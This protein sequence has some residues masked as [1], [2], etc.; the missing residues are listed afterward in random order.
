MS[1]EHSFETEE[2]FFCHA[3]IRPGVPLNAQRKIDLLE[4]D[5]PFLS[6]DR[7]FGKIVVHGHTITD[8]VVIKPNRI[9][10]D[11]GAAHHGPLS[12]IELPSLKI[13]EGRGK[14]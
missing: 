9:G 3:G 4:I 2:F 13:W 8:G 5:E 10:L 12:A 11:T 14:G 6:S 7:D 1:L